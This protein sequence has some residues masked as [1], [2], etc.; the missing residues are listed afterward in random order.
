MILAS[1]FG[2]MILGLRVQYNVYALLTGHLVGV[3]IFLEAAAR[4]VFDHQR[5]LA[6][7]MRLLAAVASALASISL[8]AMVLHFFGALPLGA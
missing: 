8:V 6:V 2:F 3:A 7:R 5:T 1:C 4:L